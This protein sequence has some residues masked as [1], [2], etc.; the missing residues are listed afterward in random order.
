M[1]L[2]SYLDMGE[3][4]PL[5]VFVMDDLLRNTVPVNTLPREPALRVNP[6]MQH[7][8][9]KKQA[10]PADAQALLDTAKKYSVRLEGLAFSR[11]I[12]RSLPMWDHFATDRTEIRR[13]SSP[14]GTTDCLKLKHRVLT[15]GDFERLAAYQNDPEHREENKS[16]CQ[17]TPCQEIKARTG[18][19]HPYACYVRAKRLLDTLPPK[20]D[21][22]G[23]HP[24]DHERPNQNI[25]QAELTEDTEAID[26][27]I[28]T[29]G[30]VGQ[31]FR[32][33][34]DGQP[35]HNGRLEAAATTAPTTLTIATAGT[36]M[37]S[38]ETTAQ[39]GGGLF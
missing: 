6:F 36:C 4:R 19:H 9:P 25:E 14:T 17:C 32:I 35:T 33:F 1:W 22:R 3:T 27:S 30:D 12:F 10:L 29:H 2:K 15:V 18:C 24:E 39:A 37:D 31:L 11:T 34:T 38:D 13:L 16:G 28:T 5:W 7:W 26:I 20:W 23:S 21:P 8:Q